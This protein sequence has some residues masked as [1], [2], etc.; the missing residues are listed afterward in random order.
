MNFNT[1]FERLVLEAVGVTTDDN[2]K[3]IKP[4]INR[5]LNDKSVVELIDLTADDVEEVKNKRKQSKPQKRNEN[6]EPVF[7]TIFRLDSVL[8]CL[9]IYLKTVDTK[10]Q[11]NHKYF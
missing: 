4:K 8:N 3:D 5:P 6:T 11:T 9:H 7:K 1:F 10:S 2:N